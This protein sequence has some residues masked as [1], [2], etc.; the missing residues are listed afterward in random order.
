M[1]VFRA[2]QV[3]RA[4]GEGPWGH[5]GTA[6]HN[7]SPFRH[8]LDL[9][10]YRLHVSGPW[11]RR[12]PSLG[13]SEICCSQ[14]SPCLVFFAALISPSARRTMADSISPLERQRN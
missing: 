14:L 3:H 7:T 13:S 9:L 10:T 12:T 8:S 5:M 11:P 1:E 4:K 2:E 6:K